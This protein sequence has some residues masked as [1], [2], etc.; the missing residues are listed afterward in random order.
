VFLDATPG[1]QYAGVGTLPLLLTTQYFDEL[2]AAGLQSAGQPSPAPFGLRTNVTGEV[3]IEYE[4]SPVPL[5][6]A[7]WLLLS[8]LGALGGAAPSRRVKLP[9][10]PSAKRAW[11]TLS[12]TAASLSNSHNRSFTFAAPNTG[13]Q[14]DR[15]PP[16]DPEP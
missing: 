2:V 15:H 12:A 14:G 7:A 9:R 3:P 4:Y 16:I 5:P 8:G 6:A 10:L 1:A 13:K 11:P